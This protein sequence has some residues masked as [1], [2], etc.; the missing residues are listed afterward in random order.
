MPAQVPI[1]LL[2]A[3]VPVF[4]S[5]GSGLL[6][7]GALPGEPNSASASSASA[8]A[9]ATPFPPFFKKFD[10]EG[11]GLI[12]FEEFIFFVTLLAIPRGEIVAAFRM[13][14]AD[15]SGSLDKDEFRAMMRVLRAHSRHG[16]AA[17]GKT[18]TGFGNGASDSAASEGERLD[19][20]ACSAFFFGRDG[21]GKLTL[22]KFE[23]FMS[24]LHSAMVSLEFAHY[25]PRRTGAMAPS[26]FGLSLVACASVADVSNFLSRV[27][28]LRAAEE[29]AEAAS[30]KKGAAASGHITEAQFAAFHALMCA[31]LF[32]SFSFLFAFF[33][34]F[35]P[36]V[37]DAPPAPSLPR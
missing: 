31:S 5:Y 24:D 33:L 32:F 9:T 12:S 3:V 1:D 30:G 13:F 22:P 28:A 15:A 19:D 6:R 29:K 8:R 18:R 7:S 26:D 37:T 11:D 23:S 25:D 36:L 27:A 2:R 17:G 21:R 20:A 4:P 14:D 10:V 35:I 16:A 34:R